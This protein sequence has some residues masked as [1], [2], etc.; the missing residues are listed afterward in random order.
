MR[1]MARHKWPLRTAAL[2]FVVIFAAFAT[3]EFFAFLPHKNE[4]NNLIIS[5]S[6]E[7]RNPPAVLFELINVAN[8]GDGNTAVLV[9]RK[10]IFM[11]SDRQPQ[12]AIA[13]Q[14]NYGLWSVLLRVHYSSYEIHQLYCVTAFNGKNQ[15][16]SELSLRLFNKPLSALTEQQLATVAVYLVA[17]QNFSTHPEL[18]EMRSSELLAKLKK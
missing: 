5:A 12:R 14:L 17:P 13:W 6:A 8:N 11:F 2:F 9:A 1:F 15:G 18:L 3:Y 10:M 7:N 4:I 16:V